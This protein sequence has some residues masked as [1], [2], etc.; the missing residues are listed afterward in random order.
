[1]NVILDIV[2]TEDNVF[3]IQIAAHQVLIGAGWLVKVQMDVDKDIILVLM[4]AL[5]YLNNVLHPQLG[6]DLSVLLLEA[7]VQKELTLK[8]ENVILIN[9]A[10]MDLFG[11]Q[12]I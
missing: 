7:F 9:L 1:M 12:H 10:E 3:F 4:D 5:L 2:G 11:I 8:V 6:M